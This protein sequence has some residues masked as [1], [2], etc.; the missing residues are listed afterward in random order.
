MDSSEIDPAQGGGQ[1]DARPLIFLS[2]SRTDLAHARPVIAL[3]E[4]QGYAVWWDGRLEGGENYLQTTEATLEGADCVVVLWSATSVESHWV[5]DEAQ[6]G[7]ERGCLVPLSIDGTFAPLGFRQFQLLDISGWDGKPTS[8]E[9][10]RILVAVRARIGG[11]AERPVPVRPMPT[12]AQPQPATP[13]PALA[14]SRRA[15]HGRWFELWRVAEYLRHAPSLLLLGVARPTGRW[16]RNSEEADEDAAHGGGDRGQWPEHF[17]RHALRDVGLPQVKVTR[18]YLRAGLAEVA[19]PHVTSQRAYHEFKEQRLET[20]HRQLDRAAETCFVLAVASVLAYLVLK[21]GGIGGLLPKHLSSDLSALF[22]FLGVAF[23]T[24]G[25]NL[26]GIRYFGDFERFG[27]IS[28]VAAEK[29]GEIEARMN[30]LL[31][32]AESALTYAAAADLMHALDEAVVD[33]I[34]SWQSVFGAKHLALPA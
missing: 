30:L 1:A 24:L 29:L 17:A 28:R 16:P 2:Y 7:R 22:T 15:W 14:L 33:E 32:G 34:A 20:V 23:P 6:R 26:A 31:T 4:A 19:L 9:A 12:P 27:A 18:A 5:R 8:P 11:G 25:A 3:L 13:A 21:S 10:E